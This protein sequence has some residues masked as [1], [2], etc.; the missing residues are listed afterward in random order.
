MPTY[1]LGCK[2]NR[3]GDTRKEQVSFPRVT[4]NLRLAPYLHKMSKVNYIKTGK[5]NCLKKKQLWYFKVTS[6]A[7][8]VAVF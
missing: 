7:L 8:K 1:R 6:A 2:S 5:L 3:Q 4:E